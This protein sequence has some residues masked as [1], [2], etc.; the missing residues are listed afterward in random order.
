[1]TLA[2][3]PLIWTLAAA[4][5]ALAPATGLASPS[6]GVSV[7]P[8]AFQADREVRP[9]DGLQQLLDVEAREAMSRGEFLRAWYLF[10]RLLQIDPDDVRALREIGRIACAAGALDYGQRTLERVSRMEE[11][12][13]P[14]IHFLRGQA[15]ISLG[16]RAEGLRVLDRAESEL[17]LAPDSRQHSLWR[18]RIYALRG[19][20]EKSEAIYDRLRSEDP[21]PDAQ[22][23]VALLDIEAHIFATD[24]R[25]AERRLHSFLERWPDNRRARAML[26]WVLENR[27]KVAEEVKV[28]SGLASEPS[29]EPAQAYVDLGRA[30]ERAMELGQALDAYRRAQKMGI[31]SVDDD[32]GRLELRLSPEVA[33]GA[34]LRRDPTGD[35][36]GLFTGAAVPFGGRWRVAAAARRES[37]GADP[38]MSLS[39]DPTTMIAA[40]ALGVHQLS[41]G[42]EIALGATAWDSEPA[43]TQLGARALYSSSQ[44]RRWHVEV[45]GTANAPWNESAATLREGGTLDAVELQAY[46]VPFWSRL[47]LIGGGRF[48]RFGISDSTGGFEHANQEFGAAGL[49]FVLHSSYGRLARAQVFNDQWTAPSLQAQSIVLSYRHYEQST[50]SPFGPRLLLVDRSR[51]DELSGRAQLVVD[52]GGWLSVA[53]VAGAGYDSIRSLW[54]WRAGGQILFSPLARARL[55]LSYELTSETVT[56]FTG[57]R[58]EGKLSLHVDL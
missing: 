27:G 50:D 46:A 52:D 54:Q 19:D 31:E 10:W 11:G 42:D 17:A 48:S 12:P 18:A 40:S 29:D 33:A 49:D 9:Y 28:R 47:V 45:S 20:L 43:G 5:V 44:A 41:W 57:R 37:V 23:D 30:H 51:L 3:K 32:I 38:T 55:S 4:V 22:K 39:G 8:E 56:G 13:D 58:H 7:D 1:M 53:A 21:S 36:D 6:S 2:D 26:A 16:R 34:V 25:G 35:I 14:E 15:L 24:W